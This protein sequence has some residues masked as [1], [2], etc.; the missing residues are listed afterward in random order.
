MHRCTVGRRSHF[1]RHTP[2]KL[3]RM[4]IYASAIRYIRIPHT[5]NSDAAPPGRRTIAVEVTV[6]SRRSTYSTTMF[7]YLIASPCRPTSTVNK[8]DTEQTLPDKIPLC[9]IP[10][11]YKGR[12]DSGPPPRQKYG[13]V[14]VKVKVW[15][16]AIVPLT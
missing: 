6:V 5:S 13:L 12:L 2:C 7:S 3:L 8:P 4:R 9:Y 16:L 1:L 11:L 14:K 15:T 10:L